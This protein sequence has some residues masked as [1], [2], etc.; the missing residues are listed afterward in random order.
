MWVWPAAERRSIGPEREEEVERDNKTCSFLQLA[1][2][3][4][5]EAT[6]RTVQAPTERGFSTGE[7]VLFAPQSTSPAE[8]KAAVQLR[9]VSINTRELV[10]MDSAGDGLN[11]AGDASWESVGLGPFRTENSNAVRRPYSVSS[12]FATEMECYSW[13]GIKTCRAQFHLDCALH[14]AVPVQRQQAEVYIIMYTEDEVLWRD[15]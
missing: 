4:E 11:V 5:E 8:H 13:D 12:S 7:L 3:S 15:V 1:P 9:P 14:Q 2:M 6:V 10:G